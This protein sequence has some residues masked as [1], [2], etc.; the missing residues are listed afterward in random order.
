M[1]Q[2]HVTGPNIEGLEWV[3]EE[4][5]DF[6]TSKN[7]V[8][9]LFWTENMP[10]KTS[11]RCRSVDTERYLTVDPNSNPA[12]YYVKWVVSGIII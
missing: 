12:V 7:K 3:K 2:S 5:V 4:V 8:L 6:T 9:I 10:I 11:N 1:L